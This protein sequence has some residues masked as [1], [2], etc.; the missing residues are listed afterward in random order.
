MMFPGM[1]GQVKAIETR[2]QTSFRAFINMHAVPAYFTLVFALTGGL[3]L[4]AVL[5]TAGGFLGTGTEP[6][7]PADLD[8]FTYLAL[9]PGGLIAAG[10]RHPGD[11]P[12]LWQGGPARPASAG[13]SRRRSTRP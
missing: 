4:L 7:S 9:L 3:Y 6:T 12:R 11:R 8:P 1:G 2:Q 10:G 13:L 5:S